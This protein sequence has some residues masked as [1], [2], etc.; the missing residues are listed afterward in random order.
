LGITAAQQS[1]VGHDASEAEHAQA[2]ARAAQELAAGEVTTS[3]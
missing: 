1:C 3:E 2:R